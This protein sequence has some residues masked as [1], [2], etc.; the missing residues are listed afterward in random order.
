M[1]NLGQ[2]LLGEIAAVRVK[3]GQYCSKGAIQHPQIIAKAPISVVPSA[4]NVSHQGKE[5]YRKKHGRNERGNS[6]RY[7]NATLTTASK[8][9]RV[10]FC[11][12]FSVLPG[13]RLVYFETTLTS[14]ARLNRN[15]DGSL[16]RLTLVFKLATTRAQ[17]LAIA[18]YF[19]TVP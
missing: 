4:H 13:A 19:P 3:S 1:H 10:F 7:H 11:H 8:A 17:R 5:G 16:F 9:A 15:R 6:Y 18:Q 14:H 2:C 12:G